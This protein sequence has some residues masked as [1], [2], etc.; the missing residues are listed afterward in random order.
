MQVG[1]VSS[2]MWKLQG[3]DKEQ[4]MEVH[5]QQAVVPMH[6]PPP[7]AGARKKQVEAQNS[8]SLNSLR[9]KRPQHDQVTA[10]QNWTAKRARMAKQSGAGASHPIDL[11]ATVAEG[12]LMAKGASGTPRP[13][14]I[15][16]STKSTATPHHLRNEGHRLSLRSCPTLAARFP[17]LV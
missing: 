2:G 15:T 13:V 1:L 9:R 17:H 7:E 16:S 3:H 14:A 8:N 11:E 10:P 5:V 4:R 6:Y 12:R